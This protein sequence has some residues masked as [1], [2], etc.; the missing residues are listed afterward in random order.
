MPPWGFHLSLVR[1][2]RPVPAPTCVSKRA[3]TLVL[4]NTRTCAHATFAADRFVSGT[5]VVMP[6][7]FTKIIAGEIP[8]CK[9]AEGVQWLAFLDINPRRAGHTLVVPKEE[10]IRIAELSSEARAAL[11]DGVAE[12]QRRLTAVF[13]TSDFQVSIHDGPLAGQEVPHVHVH[14]IPRAEGDGGRSMLAMWPDAPPIGSVAPNFPELNKLAAELQA[15]ET[16]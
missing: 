13:N 5:V 11:L 4:G 1:R 10:A 14:V 2:A 16:P 8:C 12:A 3:C 6:S 9:V 7:L 15:V